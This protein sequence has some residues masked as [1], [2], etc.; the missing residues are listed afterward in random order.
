M[1]AAASTTVM[2]YLEKRMALTVR[3]VLYKN[4]VERY[5]SPELRYYRLPLADAASL[6]INP[7]ATSEKK[8]RLSMIG[9]LV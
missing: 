7:I 6:G 3:E 2:K 8:K 9:N 5:L 4:L 1:A